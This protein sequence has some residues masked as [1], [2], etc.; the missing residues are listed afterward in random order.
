MGVLDMKANT[1]L[2]SN[3]YTYSKIVALVFFKYYKYVHI[4]T[5]IMHALIEV[6]T[7]ARKSNRNCKVLRLNLLRFLNIIFL[8]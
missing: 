7:S 6:E 4:Y 1:N 5:C 2:V 3:I 8:G